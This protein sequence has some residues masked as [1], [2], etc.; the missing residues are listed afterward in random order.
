MAKVAVIVAP[1]CEEGETL[2]IVDILRRAEVTCDM[3]G[4]GA[5]DI[6]GTH[7]IVMRTDVVFDGS[8]CDYDMVVLPG[9]YGGSD[10]MRDDERLIAAIR[11]LDARGAWVCAICAAPEALGRA[12][13]LTGKRY[14]C[15]PGVVDLIENPGTWVDEPYVVEGN[16]IT[17]QG[18]AFAYAFAYVLVDALG[19][20]SE[21]V[22][23]RMVYYNAFDVEGGEPSWQR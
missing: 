12:G 21:T 16:L 19:I 14:T 6:A 1:G 22:K 20:D 5:R 17:G 3:V 4:L 10:A 2:T 13:L 23:Q 8:L 18:P 9:G 11:E 7:H 15:Y